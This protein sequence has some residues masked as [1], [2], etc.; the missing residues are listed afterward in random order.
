MIF[1][2]RDI[3]F[4]DLRDVYQTCLSVRQLD[5]GSEIGYPGDF[6]LHYTTNLNKHTEKNPP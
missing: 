5:K 6:T 2:I 3:F 1:N 4:S